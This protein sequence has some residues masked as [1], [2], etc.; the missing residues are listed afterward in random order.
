MNELNTLNM[1]QV[2]GGAFSWDGLLGTG[3]AG[4]MGAGIAS[5]GGAAT[6]G[7]LAGPI[8]LGAAGAMSAY[9]VK[10]AIEEGV[11][12]AQTVWKYGI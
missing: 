4:A 11:L 8:A 5:A 6:I 1:E 7:A 3:G 10:A 9:L 12:T 2:S